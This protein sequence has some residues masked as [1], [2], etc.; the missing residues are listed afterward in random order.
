MQLFAQMLQTGWHDGLG[1]VLIVAGIAV[2]VQTLVFG[3][4]RPGAA[5]ILRSY[6]AAEWSQRQCAHERMPPMH[7]ANQFQRVAAVAALGFARVEAAANLHARAARELEAVDD[8]LIRLLADYRPDAMLSAQPHEVDPAPA[9]I[10][11]PLA[12]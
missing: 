2:A 7:P 11:Q 5:H 10:A 6:R 12:A 3:R 1:W 8:A 4:P 9:P